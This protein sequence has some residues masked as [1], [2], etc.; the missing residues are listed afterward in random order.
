MDPAN[1][2]I[3]EKGAPGFER[4]PTKESKT[5]QDDPTAT[6]HPPLTINRNTLGRPKVWKPTTTGE[7]RATPNSKIIPKRLQNNKSSSNA[8]TKTQD[9]SQTGAHSHKTPPRLESSLH[10]L[11]APSVGGGRI[12]PGFWTMNRVRNPKDL[13]K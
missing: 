6:R 2:F 8:K 11:P 3:S 7:P 5:L 9:A 4:S 12:R 1:S 10:L 13:M